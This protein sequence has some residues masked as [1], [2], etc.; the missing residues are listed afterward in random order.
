MAM[1]GRLTRVWLLVM[2]LVLSACTLSDNVPS[3]PTALPPVASPQNGLPTP[4][5]LPGVN[6]TS[7][8]IL[9]SRTPPGTFL[10]PTPTNL[11]F[12]G[13]VIATAPTGEYAQI[14]SPINGSNVV[15][16][17]LQASGIVGGLTRDEFTLQLVS[18]SGQ[19]LNS[20]LIT[21]QNPNR[22][23]EVP[24]SAAMTTGS[25]TGPAEVR[26]MAQNAAGTN[27]LLAQV[28][29]TLGGGG[30]AVVNPA[31]PV[32]GSATTPTGSIS[33]PQDGTTVSGPI[34]Q[35]A[36]TAG[37]IAE[38]QFVIALVAQDGTVLNSQIVSLSNSDYTVIV[39][40]AASLGTNGYRGPVELR[41]FT[42]NGQ[43]GV[44]SAFASIHVTVQ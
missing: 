23:T 7:P 21:L 22:A 28:A 32:Q 34:L 14:T 5:L 27:L 31:P 3:G 6:P 33:S 9:P 42:L 44:S 30:G 25:Y 29:I 24:W 15:P 12:I 8:G 39:P 26:V 11:P 2:A 40:W 43:G 35:V 37:G 36:G 41:A 13:S 18:S 4:S 20:Q 16:G 17:T 1:K 38:N 10:G 19:M